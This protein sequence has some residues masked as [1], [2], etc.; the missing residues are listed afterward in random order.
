MEWQFGSA[1]SADA[2]R[3]RREFMTELRE[4]G[5]TSSDF[6][7]AELIFGEL[8]SNVVRH[9]P[10]PVRVRLFWNGKRAVLSVHDEAAPFKPKFALP[11]DPM[12]ENGRGLFIARALSTSLDVTHI[13]GDGTKVSVGLPVWRS[14]SAR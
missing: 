3:S 4:S 8:I 5:S 7:G 14:S 13:A 1:S 6:A 9:A 2:R 10:G 12:S 11:A